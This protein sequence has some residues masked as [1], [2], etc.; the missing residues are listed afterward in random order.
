MHSGVKWGFLCEGRDSVCVCVCVKRLRYGCGGRDRCVCVH[1]HAP[2]CIGR[3]GCV[4]GGGRHSEYGGE[5][6]VWGEETGLC[7]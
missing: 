4:C 6:G 2:V 3:Y 7:V 1:T 5:T